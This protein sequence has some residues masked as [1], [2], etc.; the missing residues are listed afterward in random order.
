MSELWTFFT[1]AQT[2]PWFALLILATLASLISAVSGGSGEGHDAGGAHGDVGDVGD[3]G[4]DAGDL[5]GG[6]GH[7]GDLHHGHAD[8]ADHDAPHGVAGTVLAAVGLGALGRLPLALNLALFAL[9]TSAA[10]LTVQWIAW[11]YGATMPAW[12]LAGLGGASVTWA[13]LRIAAPGLDRV[14]PRNHTEALG[15]D[16]MIG[17][18]GEIVLGTARTGLPAEARVRDGF[19]RNH[20]LLVEPR[21][22]APELPGGTRVVILVHREGKRFLAAEAG[23]DSGFTSAAS[24]T[25]ST[26]PAP[27]VHGDSTGAGEPPVAQ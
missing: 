24:T 16:D 15:W 27:A 13:L 5:H 1:H 18:E 14:L 4:G 2:A 22:G 12:W 10:S 6:D 17:L 11:R 23:P 9:L 3:V 19:G 8:G 26:A 25:A 7:A 20:Y 21:D